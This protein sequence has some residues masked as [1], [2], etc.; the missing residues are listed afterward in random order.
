MITVTAMLAATNGDSSGVASRRARASP[1][2]SSTSRKMTIGPV[3]MI[4]TIAS[5]IAAPS[6]AP[7]VWKIVSLAAWWNVARSSRPR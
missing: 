5:A 1:K 6:S 4:D 7:R 3:P 2:H